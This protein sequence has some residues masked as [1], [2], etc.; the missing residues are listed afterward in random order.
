MPDTTTQPAAT[1]PVDDDDDRC[2]RC[3]CWCGHCPCDDDLDRAAE[4]GSVST[5]SAHCCECGASG[6]DAE[7]HCTCG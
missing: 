4:D 6:Y 1:P 3:G 5:F 7:Y 2:E